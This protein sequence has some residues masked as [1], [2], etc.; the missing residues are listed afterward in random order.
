MQ[1]AVANPSGMQKYNL[2]TPHRR[3]ITKAAARGHKKGLVDRCFDDPQVRSSC[4][5]LYIIII[6]CYFF[7]A[8]HTQVRRNIIKKFVRMVRAEMKQMCSSEVKSVL[9]DMS[10]DAVKSFT[11]K[12]FL[13]EVETNAPIL[14]SFLIGCTKTRRTRPNQVAVVGMCVAILLRNRYGRMNLIH[15]IIG[16]ILY[17]GHAAKKVS[18]NLW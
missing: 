2:T 8:D 4:C 11:W 3:H 9:Q 7:G 15:K 6:I 13:L 5:V 10:N 14:H 16:L 1:V 17:T 12:S 18:R